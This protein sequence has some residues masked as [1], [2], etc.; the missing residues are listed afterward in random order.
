MFSIF[1]KSSIILKYIYQTPYLFY[2]KKDYYSLFENIHMN[3]FDRYLLLLP[4]HPPNPTLNVS[5]SLYLTLILLKVLINEYYSD[6]IHLLV[7]FPKGCI[8]LYTL[9]IV[10]VV[11]RFEILYMNSYFWTFINVQ[12]CIY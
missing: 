11:K 8:S 9:I 7:Y 12:F 1:I 2:Y 6:L 3:I 5:P 4:P 10:I